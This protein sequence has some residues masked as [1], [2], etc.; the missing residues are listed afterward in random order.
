[1]SAVDEQQILHR[2]ARC[3]DTDDKVGEAICE[4]ALIGL[5]WNINSSLAEWFPLTS[6]RL[7]ALEAELRCAKAF[8]DVAVQ[9][10]NTAWAEN[11]RLQAALIKVRGALGLH[12]DSHDDL[13]QAVVQL[14]VANAGLQQ[15][16]AD[17]AEDADR[18][19][20]RLRAELATARNDTLGSARGNGKQV[21]F[22]EREFYVL[23]NFSAFKLNWRGIVFDTAEH[24]YHWTRFPDGSPERQIIRE[25]ASAHDAFRFAQENKHQQLSHWESVKVDVMRDILRA[26]A[27]QHEYVRRKLLETGERELI[28]DSWRDDFWGW[29]PS[30]GGNNM[31]GKLWMEIRTALKREGGGNG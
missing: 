12:R 9:Q 19:C 7:D 31:L 1:M 3:L 16:A 6:E 13:E 8:H 14:R 28:E 24:A 27:E 10:R 4:A 30:R 11:E 5:K 22:Y 20:V 21:L 26:K 15:I 18:E 25:S 2:L 17:R 23:S 29:G